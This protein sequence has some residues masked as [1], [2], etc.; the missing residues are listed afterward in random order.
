MQV[1]EVA[2]ALALALLLASGA[3]SVVGGA[4][5]ARAGAVVGA[6]LAWGGD[7]CWQ[8]KTGGG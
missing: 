4:A 5:A 8:H 6:I 3:P 7:R 1:V 2:L